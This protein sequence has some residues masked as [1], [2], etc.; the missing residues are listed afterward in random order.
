M[1]EI[2]HEGKTYILKSNVE[3][4]IKERISKVASRANEAESRYS[5]LEKQIKDFQSKQ[6]SFDLLSS[7]VSDLKN[8]LK[9]SESKFS[10]Y[11]SISQLGITNQDV[12]DLLE[13]QYEKST[14]DL[15]ERPDLSSWLEGHIKNVDN[16]PLSIQHHLQSLSSSEALEDTPE[17]APEASP[18]ASQNDMINAMQLQSLQ[19]MNQAASAPPNVNRG[20]MPAPDQKDIITRSLTD[21]NYYNQNAEAIR[22][23]WMAKFGRKR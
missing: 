23:A 18:E 2:E 6:A 20:A 3:S 4:I 17:A 7:Q 9:K 1:N 15:K 22:Q 13:W 5:E 12:I 21:Q 10:R 19:Q 11:Q 8:Q 16:A 14:K